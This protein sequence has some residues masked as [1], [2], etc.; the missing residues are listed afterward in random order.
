MMDVQAR[1]QK[2][3]ADTQ[4][5]MMRLQLDAQERQ[6]QHDLEMQKLRLQEL[7][8]TNKIQDQSERLLLDKR[9]AV[10][11]DDLERDKLAVQGTPAVPYGQVTGDTR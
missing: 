5:D 9:K 8:L 2:F 10:M 6:R 11:V 4:R 3:Q 1:A 7:E